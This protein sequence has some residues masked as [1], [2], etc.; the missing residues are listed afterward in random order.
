MH[1]T[2]TPSPTNTV[3]RFS[4][5]PTATWATSLLGALILAA[6][7]VTAQ[8]QS[9]PN[10]TL[11]LADPIVSV[12][13][14]LRQISPTR[15]LNTTVLRPLAPSIARVAPAL[16]PKTTSRDPQ[17]GSGTISSGDRAGPPGG[18]RDGGRQRDRRQDRQH[19]AGRRRQ[20]NGGLRRRW[21]D[22]F[23]DHARDHC[24]TSGSGGSR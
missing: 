14:S 2:R 12:Q 5:L 9:L 20:S 19:R 17:H 18:A 1:R 16:A 11:R 21:A 6:L 3:I 8:G 22:Q 7:P 24:R 23:R 10:N 4:G 15:T 13:P